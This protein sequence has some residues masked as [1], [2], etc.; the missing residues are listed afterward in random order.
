[1]SKLSRAIKFI[2][3]IWIVAF[4][5]AVPQAMQFGVVD[6]EGGGAYCTVSFSSKRYYLYTKKLKC[7]IWPK[8]NKLLRFSH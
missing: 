5:L 2:L 3:A 7:K 6:V 1:M 4:C 8:F